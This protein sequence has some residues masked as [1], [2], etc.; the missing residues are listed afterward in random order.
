MV[1]LSFPILIK[2]CLRPRLSAAEPEADTANIKVYL[3]YTLAC[4]DAICGEKKTRNLFQRPDVLPDLPRLQHRHPLRDC[5]VSPQAADARKVYPFGAGTVT[6]A[7]HGHLRN[8]Q[9][10]ATSP[11]LKTP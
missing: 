7:L 10:I 6:Q 1:S 9:K 5:P 11:I 2:P 4:C 3:S 8:A